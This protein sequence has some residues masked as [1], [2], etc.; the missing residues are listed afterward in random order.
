MAYDFMIGAL[1]KRA[2]CKVQTIRYYEEIG[3]M[4]PP[5]RA[6]N[7]RRIYN[8]THLERLTFIRHSRSLGFSLD[9]IRELLAL[10]DEEARP[11][12]EVDAIARGHLDE[13]ERKIAALQTLESELKRM[14]NQ[15]A[16]GTVANCRIIKV[17]A[18]HSLCTQHEEAH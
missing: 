10:A 15:C 5:L 18:D 4:P 11:C 1:A 17:L 12:A 6:A 2:E 14:V 7:N 16:G 8:D 13:V 3:V 9:T